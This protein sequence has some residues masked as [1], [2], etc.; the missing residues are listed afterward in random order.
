MLQN[1]SHAHLNISSINCDFKKNISEFL[2]VEMS[3]QA[4]QE[5]Y[6]SVGRLGSPSKQKLFPSHSIVSAHFFSSQNT[7]ASSFLLLRLSLIDKSNS[8]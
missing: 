1:H 5:G 6:L 3:P 7:V 4:S 2:R 8:W